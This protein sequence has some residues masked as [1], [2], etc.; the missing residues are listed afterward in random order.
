VATLNHQHVTVR[1]LITVHMV[2]GQWLHSNHQHVT[3]RTYCTYGTRTA[4]TLNHQHVTVRTLITVHMV[5]GQWL[6]SIINMLL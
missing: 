6:H 1:T 4:A 5:P 3:V 2:P